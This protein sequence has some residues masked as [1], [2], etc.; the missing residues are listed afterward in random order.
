MQISDFLEDKYRK[1]VKAKGFK[2]LPNLKVFKKSF[3]NFLQI[4]AKKGLGLVPFSR[5]GWVTA[6]VHFF[7]VIFIVYFIGY[8]YIYIYIYIYMYVCICA[9]LHI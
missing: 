4:P 9:Y 8:I 5:D 2:R 3:F 6:K 1:A 7:C